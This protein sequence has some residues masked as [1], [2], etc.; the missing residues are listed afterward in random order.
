LL[1]MG[2]VDSLSIVASLSHEK[3]KSQH[4]FVQ[5]SFLILREL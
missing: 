3:E 4:Y 2:E 1:G 5:S